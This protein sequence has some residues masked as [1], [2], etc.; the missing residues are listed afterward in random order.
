MV[1][2]DLPTEG[3]HTNTHQHTHQWED[4]QRTLR[5][6][7]RYQINQESK[8]LHAKKNEAKRT[9]L[10]PTPRMREQM[11]VNM[12]NYTTK[13]TPNTDTRNGQTLQQ[14]EQK[15]DKLLIEQHGNR[16]I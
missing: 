16:T 1:Q 14:P 15:P 8:F 11:A 13:H 5:T 9:T 6:A 10:Q 7:K 4:C 3:T 12:A 2:Q